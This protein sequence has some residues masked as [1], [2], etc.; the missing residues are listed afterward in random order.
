MEFTREQKQAVWERGRDIL[1]SA[2]A[3]AGK[4][5]VLVSRMAEMIMDKTAPVSVDEFLVMTFTN[6]A[7]REMKERIEE[8]LNKRLEKDRE[9]EYLKRQLRMVKYADISTV[10]SFCNRLLR[11]HFQELGLDPSFRIGEEGELFLL[12]HQAMEDLLEEAYSS[13]KETFFTLVESYAPG[14]SD[15]ML[16]EIIDQ[17]YRFSRGFPN[18]GDWFASMLAQVEKLMDADTI[19]DTLPMALILKSAEQKIRT[20]IREAERGITFYG[21]SR[22]PERF[23]ALLEAD[24]NILMRLEELHDYSEIR[25]YLLDLSLP[26]L[27]RATKKEK[28]WPEHLAVAKEVHE[29]LREGIRSLQTE[30]FFFDLQELCRENEQI[31][32]LLAELVFLVTR[33]EELYFQNKKEKNVYDFDDLEHLALKLLVEAYDEEKNPIPSQ[34]AKLLSGKY[35]A[36]FVDEYQDTNLV[37]ETMIRVLN[38]G[39]NTHLFA[40]GDVKQSIYRFRQARPDLF[41]AR[42][43]AFDRED[44]PGLNIELRDNF[45]SAPGVLHFCNF[46]FSKLMKREFGGVDYDEKTALRPGQNGP[47]EDCGEQSEVLLL[48]E[49]EEKEQLA[50]EYDATLAETAMIARRMRELREE[51][52]E[53][54][55]MVILL[56]SGAGRA[57]PMAEFLTSR[58]IPCICDSRT[59]YFHTREVEIMLNYLAVIDNVYQ[60]IPMASAMLSS[61]GGFT[62][63]ELAR[64]M[65]QVSLPMRAGVTLYDLMKLYEEEGEDQVLSDHVKAFMSQLACFRRKKKEMPLHE[66]LWEI[67]QKT[68]FYYD[69]QLMPGGERRKENLLMLLQK[70]EEYEKTVFKGLF[71]FLRYLEQLKSYEIDLGEAAL[72]ENMENAV[73]I[74]T[75]HKSKGLEFPVVFVSGLSRQFNLLDANQP[76]LGHPEF[77][78]GLEYVDMASRV[79]F[80]SLMKRAI[81]E[82]LRKDT[83]EEELRILYVAMTRAQKKLILTGIIKDTLVEKCAKRSGDLGDKLSARSFM[84]WLLPVLSEEDSAKNLSKKVVHLHELSELFLETEEEKEE[85]SFKEAMEKIPVPEDLTPVQN[86]FSHVYP[87]RDAISCKRKYSVSE[88]KRLSMTA[89]SADGQADKPGEDAPKPLHEEEIPVPDFLKRGEKEIAG[90]VRGTIVHKVMELMRFGNIHDKKELYEE[91]KRVENLCPE[92]REISMKSVYHGLENF[93]FSE[94]GAQIRRMDQA[95]RYHRE[96]PFTISMPTKVPAGEA[97]GEEN[98]IVQG[99]IDAYG[100]GEDGLWLIDY[101]TDRVKPGEEDLLLDRYQ[102]Q[103]LYYKTALERI[104][105]QRVIRSYIYSF[106][107]GKYIR[108]EENPPLRQ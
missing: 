75:I 99:V 36:V 1:V 13:G 95:G 89:L 106:A 51:G 60:D 41:L 85:P 9:N 45:R 2:G 100:E 20:L 102:K 21:Q 27:P 22:E 47:M 18:A 73:K 33:Y 24:K 23:Y 80:P 54:K 59:G 65:V 46:I 29:V 5:R 32:P 25:G 74:M 14:R 56:R 68:G 71:Y 26:A 57:E 30:Y 35:K 62:E 101:K 66:L 81:R 90:T 77:G 42:Y 50:R 40:V 91:L 53:Y 38:A 93:L 52:Y 19:E 67:Y 63:E 98:I 12:R 6:A 55:D 92:T 72:N 8:E 34:T 28:E 104:L 78:I 83:L 49:D 107:L 84:E 11:G 70:A 105:G 94:I 103:M 86:A 88:L 7:A 15:R 97:D 82:R 43:E 69:V 79:H 39:E 31:Y 16:E 4:T 58:G 17:L 87:Y 96:V 3:G 61:I 76:L 108:C 10:H 37:Q 64:L 48:K 44:N